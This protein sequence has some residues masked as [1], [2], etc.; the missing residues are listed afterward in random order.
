[1]VVVS[2]VTGQSKARPVE[3]DDD[4]TFFGDVLF[5]IKGGDNK[6]GERRNF[7]LDALD[8]VDQ[9][10]L[11]SRD[12]SK[13]GP[14]LSGW[15]S[16]GKVVFVWRAP[17]DGARDEVARDS[18]LQALWDKKKPK[19]GDYLLEV[20]DG[21]TGSVAG[22]AELLTG[23]FSFVPENV[24]AMGDWL[25]VADNVNRVL[26]FSIS[27]GQEV[28]RWFGSHPQISRNGRRLCLSSGR[29]H[30]IVYDL[31]SLKQIDDLQFGNPISMHAFSADGTKLFV[32]TSD[33]TAFQ[34]DVSAAFR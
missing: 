19:E 3:K 6:R 21:R 32:L 12:F 7:T 28:A 16:S 30:L 13:Q 17:S 5:R 10:P 22:G 20:V 4:V 25:V 9:K 14:S 23:K 26:L 11:W 29:G 34:F 15:S 18:K 31:Q 2:P 24:E 1:M 8:I 33:Q 27:T